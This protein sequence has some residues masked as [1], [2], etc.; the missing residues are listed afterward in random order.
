MASF[1]FFYGVHDDW[2][3]FFFFSSRRRHTRLTCDWSS[4]VCSSDLL[5]ERAG[6]DRLLHADHERQEIRRAADR[7]RAVLRSGLAEARQVLGDREVAGH[8]YFLAAADAH[9]VDAA[10]DRLVAAEDGR[11]HVVE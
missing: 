5:A 7:G 1:L 11:D 10:D 2:Y 4:D 3:C 6:L 9:A 8:A